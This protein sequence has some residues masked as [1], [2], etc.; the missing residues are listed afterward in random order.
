MPTA[1]NAEELD[2]EAFI[3]KLRKE[4]TVQGYGIV[5]L[6]GSGISHGSGIMI[7]AALGGYLAYVVWRMI[8]D[9]DK[10]ESQHVV[11]DLTSEGWP[12]PPSQQEVTQVNQWATRWYCKLL[13]LHNVRP[14]MSHSF[15]LNDLYQSL[16]TQYFL[17]PVKPAAFDRVEFEKWDRRDNEEKIVE[18]RINKINRAIREIHNERMLQDRQFAFTPRQGVSRTSRRYIV[19]TAVRSLFDW[20]L[21]LQFLARL[22]TRDGLYYLEEESDQ[23][24]VDSFNIFITQGRKPCLAH[25]MVSFLTRPLRIRKLLTTNFDTLLE[26]AYRSIDVPLEVFSIERNSPLPNPNSTQIRRS[27]IKLHGSMHETRADFS[28]DESPS[29]RDKDTFLQYVWPRKDRIPV[30]VPSHLLVMGTS[31]PDKRNLELIKH[32]CDHTPAFRVFIIA[33][34]QD[35]VDFIKENFGPEYADHLVFTQSRNLDLTLYEMYQAFTYSLPPAGFKFEFSQYIPPFE[36]DINF[37]PPRI[38]AARDQYTNDQTFSSSDEFHDQAHQLI[39]NPLGI[40][41]PG[42]PIIVIDGEYGV[43]R[44]GA[45]LFYSLQNTHY[46]NCIWFE[47]EDFLQPH[48]LLSETF[49]TISIKL[50]LY[51]VEN[52]STEFAA[53]SEIENSDSVTRRKISALCHHYGIDPQNW[54]LFFYGRN[55]AGSCA[56]YVETTIVNVRISTD[57]KAEQYAIFASIMD[58]LAGFGFKII[59]MPLTEKKAAGL[60]KQ[61]LNTALGSILR[62]DDAAQMMERCITNP[63]ALDTVAGKQERV[64]LIVDTQP[65]F[66]LASAI[67]M[68]MYKYGYNEDDISKQERLRF[69]YS[70]TLFRQSRH[71]SALFAE[72]AFSSRQ[73][74]TRYTTPIKSPTPNEGFYNLVQLLHG[75]KIR[76]FNRKPGGLAWMFRDIRLLTNALSEQIR[77]DENHESASIDFRHVRTR[78]HFWI[79]QWYLRAF[80]SSAHVDPLKES[81][82]HTMAAIKCINQAFL[83]D[84]QD[85]AYRE[86]LL[87][88]GLSALA[89]IMMSARESL[90]YWITEHRSA[91]LFY[92]G[93][94]KTAL[95]L[96]FSVS[97]SE[98]NGYSGV[99]DYVIQCTHS[100]N[101]PH[102]PPRKE[103]VR[104]VHI[105]LMSIRNECLKLERDILKHSNYYPKVKN[106]GAVIPTVPLSGVAA[107]MP[108]VDID[109]FFA[110][111]PGDNWNTSLLNKIK[112]M[113]KEIK[114]RLRVMNR[115]F[116]SHLT[117]GAIKKPNHERI[118]TKVLDFKHETAKQFVLKPEKL[119]VFVQI[120]AEYLYRAIRHVKFLN[121]CL[122]M[123]KKQSSGPAK[124]QPNA[125][126]LSHE[127]FYD[128]NIASESRIISHYWQQIGLWSQIMLEL[129]HYLPPAY[130]FQENKVKIKLLTFAGLSLGRL[131]KFYSAHQMLNEGTGIVYNMSVPDNKREIVILRLRRA[132]VHLLEA[133]KLGKRL[134]LLLNKHVEESKRYSIDAT[135]RLHV[136]KLDDAW[137]ILDEVE[138]LISS[139]MHS[140]LWGGKL[141]YL[142]LMILAE[143]YIP[144][145]HERP[146]AYIPRAMSTCDNTM[147]VTLKTIEQGVLCCGE[148]AYRQLCFFNIFAKASRKI[149]DYIECIDPIHH[150][151]RWQR[152]RQNSIRLVLNVSGTTVADI[153]DSY[154]PDW[155]RI[156]PVIKEDD[157]SESPARHDL[158]Q[159]IVASFKTVFAPTR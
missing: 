26:D 101:S 108:N 7:G 105:L 34:N 127:I 134:F 146:L 103:L 62:R 129:L 24:V 92:W 67:G 124:S 54:C 117:Q 85:F 119:Y 144:K 110:Y 32:V 45:S 6:I 44:T 10:P 90:R 71:V 157:I 138:Q 68:L 23:Y 73:R 55:V 152:Y 11:V 28:L 51:S 16:N 38:I 35:T 122:C 155:D 33:F 95:E 39:F 70:A 69:I 109:I 113:P 96:D 156:L 147:N 131:G 81:L 84:K 115:I 130:L 143:L 87:V 133:I 141:Y 4:V 139:C 76:F 14:E 97:E 2:R 19:E 43:T 8:K 140:S 148:D 15:T 41:T 42:N 49:R 136:T 82:F 94:I 104:F 159:G 98:S 59:Y 126:L 66:G 29:A 158:R 149:R 153:P 154:C 60:R 52:I 27:L 64:P 80:S 72:S 18:R 142:R 93:A 48:Q 21:A 89:K 79:G 91:E 74:Y 9:Y 1:P 120:A 20:R 65:E 151:D 77:A 102:R 125:D 137:G 22:K 111:I 63:E 132:E 75:E 25:Q 100:G 47:L 112:D 36:G 30:G 107:R 13:E 116:R 58:T 31:I 99:E 83:N 114:D 121:R 57:W 50:G 78:M 5:P 37:H 150:A 61:I 46:R 56:G 128:E 118:V 145:K 53:D 86:T 12:S 40:A 17:P 135:F 106:Y 88:S 3:E 123:K